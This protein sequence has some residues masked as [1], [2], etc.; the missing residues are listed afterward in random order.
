LRAEAAESGFEKVVSRY[1]RFVRSYRSLNPRNFARISDVKFLKSRKI[2][3]N[4]RINI[5]GSPGRNN[6]I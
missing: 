5:L 4:P 1:K 3:K 6:G 2:N